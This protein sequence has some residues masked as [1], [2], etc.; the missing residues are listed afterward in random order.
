ML[1]IATQSSHWYDES[2]PE[3]S[4]KRIRDCGFESVDYN[5]HCLFLPKSIR[6]NERSAFFD[7]P[8]EEMLFG[9]NRQ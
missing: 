3:E 9:K 2:S 4:I 6:A 8:I 1:E 7:Q 5:I